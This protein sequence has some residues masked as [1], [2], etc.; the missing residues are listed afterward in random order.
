M[1]HSHL[2]KCGHALERTEGIVEG[3]LKLLENE[4]EDLG[5]DAR[6]FAFEA[7]VRQIQAEIALAQAEL[8][9]VARL[10]DE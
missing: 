2:F 10:V 7:L 5:N 6:F 9:E 3:T 4:T 1:V 8:D